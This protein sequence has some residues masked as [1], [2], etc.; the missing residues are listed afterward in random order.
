MAISK[1][2]RERIDT[3]LSVYVGYLRGT[4]EFAGWMGKGRMDNNDVIGGS[5]LSKSNAES[6]YQMRFVQREHA[7]LGQ[8][9]MMLGEFAACTHCGKHE[10]KDTSGENGQRHRTYEIP[11]VCP[12]C[13]NRGYVFLGGKIKQRGAVA[14][15]A[16]REYQGQ[17]YA[18]IAALIG[19]E[20]RQYEKA[21]QQGLEDVAQLLDLRDAFLRAEKLGSSIYSA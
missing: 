9:K 5:G 4:S 12:A 7:L 20:R 2:M 17:T 3:L 18:E 1:R 16:S 19:M 8:A 21:Y 11:A 13:E 10:V 6:I 14:L 15:H